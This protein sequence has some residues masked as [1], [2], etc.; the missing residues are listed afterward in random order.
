LFESKVVILFDCF[1]G[2]EDS[3]VEDDDDNDESEDEESDDE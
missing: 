2:D 3:Y 1:I